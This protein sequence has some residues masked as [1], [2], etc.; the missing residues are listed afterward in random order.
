VGYE[1]RRAGGAVAFRSEPALIAPGPDGRL[2]LSLALSPRLPGPAEVVITAED[3]VSGRTVERREAFAVD[4]AAPPLPALASSAPAAMPAVGHDANG[5]WHLVRLYRQGS[6]EAAVG[7]WARWTTAERVEA[8]RGLRR[9]VLSDPGAVAV[10]ALLTIEVAFGVAPG[11]EKGE[12]DEVRR[13]IEAIAEAGRRDELLLLWL[14]AVGQRYEYLTRFAQAEAFLEECLKRSPS[15]PHANL[16]LGS[17]RELRASLS[18]AFRDPLPA[19]NVPV[20]SESV[21]KLREKATRASDATFA[22]KAYRRVLADPVLGPEARLR[23]GRT[24][25]LLDKKREAV[26]E[27]ETASESRDPRLRAMAF[28]FLAR[29]EGD[30]P[31]ASLRRARAA[32]E[33]LPGSQVVAT[34][35]A[36]AL[37]RAGELEEGAAVMRAALSRPPAGMDA[38]MAYQIGAFNTSARDA[39]RQRVS[40]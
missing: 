7:E 8:L 18:V 9:E 28:L 38:W 25:L 2:S 39:L 23:L 10:A 14:A 15:N 36:Y 11:L 34:A 27:L 12:L 40:P 37:G 21:V 20:G 6:V 1:L 19:V 16:A 29:V 26:A 32:Q 4:A 30:D 3:E 31:E 5:L 24:L 17:L 35:L 33:A 22:E 13:M